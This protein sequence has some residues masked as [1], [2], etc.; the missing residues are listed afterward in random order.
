MACCYPSGYWSDA[1]HFLLHK[2]CSYI[3]FVSFLV[4]FFVQKC[5]KIVFLPIDIASLATHFSR[6]L[7]SCSNIGLKFLPSFWVSSVFSHSVVLKL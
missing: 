4:G 6:H 7:G 3:S 1:F 5:K 2:H